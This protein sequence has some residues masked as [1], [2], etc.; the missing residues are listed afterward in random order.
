MESLVEEFII[1]TVEGSLSS[2]MEQMN[3]LVN[4]YGEQAVD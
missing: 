4:A 2:A 1:N 3:N